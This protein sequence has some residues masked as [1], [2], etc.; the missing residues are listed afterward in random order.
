MTRYPLVFGLR[1]LIQGEGFLAGVAV[2]GRALMHEEEDGYVWI[3]GLNPGGFSETGESVT[4]AL[5]K[6][7]RAYTAILFDIASESGSFTEFERGVEAFFADSSPLPTQ[8]WE[9]AVEA[10]R[11][12]RV[13][14]D[15]L[16]KKP[17][18]EVPVRIRV[19]E[20]E[21]PS[22]RNNEVEVGPALAA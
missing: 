10:V 6:F 14:A 19:V 11:A 15:W 21:Q 16:T 3:E 18:D 12:G 4:E 5:E 7:R 22:S 20:F 8:E 17:A 13:S 2:D 1:D 9:E